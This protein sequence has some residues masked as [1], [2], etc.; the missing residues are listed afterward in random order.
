MLDAESSNGKFMLLCLAF[1]WHD[2]KRKECE[3][4]CAVKNVLLWRHDAFDFCG[5]SD[6]FQSGNQT[7][8]YI[9]VYLSRDDLMM[10]DVMTHHRQTKTWPT[11]CVYGHSVQTAMRVWIPKHKHCTHT[12]KIWAK[13]CVVDNEAS[14]FNS[15][16]LVW[17]FWFF[18]Y[19]LL[20]LNVYIQKIPL[21]EW[22]KKQKIL[23]T[24]SFQ[25]FVSVSEIWYEACMWRGQLV[26][27]Q[28]RDAKRRKSRRLWCL[29]VLRLSIQQRIYIYIYLWVSMWRC[30]NFVAL[31]V[32]AHLCV[33]V[34]RRRFNALTRRLGLFVFKRMSGSTI[35]H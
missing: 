5:W 34:A 28:D 27:S 6:T 20:P 32:R 4:W 14:R 30:V 26:A 2:T 29:L 35:M 12:F 23:S 7:D 9:K 3:K 22:K 15:F 31:Y 8:Y 21:D 1:A 25:Y 16:R 18:F 10:I 17:A 11:W 19:W 33:A 13:S 24:I